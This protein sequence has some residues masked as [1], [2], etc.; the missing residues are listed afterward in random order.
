MKYLIVTFVFLVVSLSYAV[1]DDVVKNLRDKIILNVE[2]VNTHKNSIL[3][4]TLI[5]NT[6][7]LEMFKNGGLK[8]IYYFDDKQIMYQE[9]NLGKK[10]E[11]PSSIIYKNFY[12]LPVIKQEKIF[13]GEL[14]P[15]KSRVYYYI[16]IKNSSE[17]TLLL[18]ELDIKTDTNYLLL[19]YKDEVLFNNGFKQDDVKLYLKEEKNIFKFKFFPNHKIYRFILK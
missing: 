16:G 10:V 7:D 19:N 3:E 9:T 8:N 17:F 11:L 13:I 2:L 5:D 12:N 14:I 1:E 6:A 4:K 18:F 15:F